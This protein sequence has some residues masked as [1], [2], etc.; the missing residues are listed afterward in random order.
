MNKYV[1]LLASVGFASVPAMAQAAAPTLSDVFGASGITAAGYIDG[2]YTAAFNKGQNIAYHT[3]DTDANSFELNQAALTLSYLPTDGFGGLV[4]V[5]TGSDGK[6]ISGSYGD[7]SGAF[8]LTQA[9]AQ[10]AHGNLTVIAGRFVTLSGFEVIDDTK[11]SNI[12]R[13]LLFQNAEPLVH[14]G[15]RAGYKVSDAITAYLGVS[16]SAVSGSAQ[17]A[18]KHKTL[19]TGVVLT[20]TSTVTV[21]VTNYYGVD[22]GAVNTDYLD[23]VASLQATK[24][25][26]LAINADYARFVGD[27]VDIYVTGVAAYANLQIT[28]SFKGSLRGEYLSTKNYTFTTD[29][30]APPPKSKLEEITL[31]GDYAVTSSFDVLG[32]FRYDFSNHK[33]YPDPSVSTGF[34]DGEGGFTPAS[35]KKSQGEVL[36]KAIWKFGTPVPTT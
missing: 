8:A 24:A 28:D 33:V 12:S 16:N 25:L 10:W 19:E 21:A 5:I 27:G 11:N 26:Q 34:D 1:G 14:T 4:N 6:V 22:G 9:Y 3:F 35:G 18:D 15:I 29:S 32:E 13:S 2:S 17:D 30:T 20:P 23:V 7:G 31:T 36:L